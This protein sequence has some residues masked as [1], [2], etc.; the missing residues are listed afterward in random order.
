M[1]VDGEVRDRIGQRGRAF[2]AGRVDAVFTII[3]S[4]GVPARIDWPTIRCC[5]PTMAPFA[6]SPA[7]NVCRY[8]GR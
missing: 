6:S 5:Q 7:F 1:H 2:D 8:A 3:A 4:N